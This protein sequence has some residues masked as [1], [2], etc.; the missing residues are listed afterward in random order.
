MNRLKALSNR[1]FA[2]KFTDE[3]LERAKELIAQILMVTSG[4][5]VV[6]ERSTFGEDNLLELLDIFQIRHKNFDRSTFAE[7]LQLHLFTFT[8]NH[9]NAYREWRKG[10]F[11]QQGM[12]DNGD[13]TGK[14]L[15]APGGESLKPSDTAK[16]VSD[17]LNNP[18]LPEPIKDGLADGLLDL[19]NSHINQTEFNEWEK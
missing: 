14:F 12:N 11:Q 6:N 5:C 10:V 9:D 1:S 7:N 19:F 15:D 2:Q 16:Q 3:E 8:A 18:D 17:L 13:E 4:V